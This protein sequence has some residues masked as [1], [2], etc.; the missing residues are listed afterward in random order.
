MSLNS[1][2]ITEP[3]VIFMIC[4]MCRKD[5]DHTYTELPPRQSP[6]EIIGGFCEKCKRQ[7]GMPCKADNFPTVKINMHA[8]LNSRCIRPKCHNPAMQNSV[9]CWICKKWKNR[10]L[11][12]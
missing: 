8:L 10:I 7:L 2:T 3:V 9:Y 12:P 5:Y 4:E 11:K 6:M 1:G